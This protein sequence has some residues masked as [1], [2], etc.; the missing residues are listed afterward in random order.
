[1]SRLNRCQQ[2]THD[3][4]SSPNHFSSFISCS[5]HEIRT[6]LFML[7]FNLEAIT[8]NIPTISLPLLM[9]SCV[10]PQNVIQIIRLYECKSS[11][12]AISIL[13]FLIHCNIMQLKNNSMES[14]QQ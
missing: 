2:I 11:F 14:G 8:N 10:A 1:M 9:S 4:V 5:I 12:I 13:Q 6:Y 7:I 3:V